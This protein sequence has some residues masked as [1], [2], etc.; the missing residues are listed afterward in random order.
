MYSFWLFIEF[1]LSGQFPRLRLESTKAKILIVFTH[2]E[3]L[4]E[5]WH[6]EFQQCLKNLLNFYIFLKYKN[7]TQTFWLDFAEQPNFH[8]FFF[9]TLNAKRTKRLKCRQTWAHV[10]FWS[11]PRKLKTH[12]QHKF[13]EKK[14]HDQEKVFTSQIIRIR[15]RI[16]MGVNKS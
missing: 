9:L 3:V 13:V 5:I 16:L 12:L 11:V 2:K 10:Y 8:L 7:W 1:S 14:K 6:I 4:S 15:I